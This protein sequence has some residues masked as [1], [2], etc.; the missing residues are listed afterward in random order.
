[1]GVVLKAV[2]GSDVV[3]RVGGNGD[4]EESAENEGRDVETHDD[5]SVVVVVIV[6]DRKSKEKKTLAES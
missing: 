5:D 3:M 1:M 4:R 6:V 2:E